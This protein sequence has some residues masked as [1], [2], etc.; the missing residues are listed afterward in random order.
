VDGGHSW[1][2]LKSLLRVGSLGSRGFSHGRVTREADGKGNDYV[3]VWSC[4]LCFT[5]VDPNDLPPQLLAGRWRH[6]ERVFLLTLVGGCVRVDRNTETVVGTQPVTTSWGV[7][8]PRVLALALMQHCMNRAARRCC[9]RTTL[10]WSLWTN[11]QG[12][13][14]GQSGPLRTARQTRARTR[15]PPRI[16]IAIGPSPTACVPIGIIVGR[17]RNGFQPAMRRG[18]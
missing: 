13:T 18:R 17:D 8:P 4:R 6:R 1:D 9:G 7:L 11:L 12:T 14:P 10:L 5:F 15:V 2:K 3:G 16:D